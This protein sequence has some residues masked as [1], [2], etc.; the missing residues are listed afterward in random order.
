MKYVFYFPTV[1][2]DHPVHD[3]YQHYK[4]ISEYKKGLKTIILYKIC[5]NIKN[6]F[7]NIRKV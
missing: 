6:K 1:E 2:K 3:M 7:Q 4:Q 5:T